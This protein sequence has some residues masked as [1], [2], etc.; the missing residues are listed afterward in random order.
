VY[1]VNVGVGVGVLVGVGVGG[2]GFSTTQAIQ[3]SSDPEYQTTGV[4]EVTVGSICSLIL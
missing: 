1:P 3:L 4:I 2:H